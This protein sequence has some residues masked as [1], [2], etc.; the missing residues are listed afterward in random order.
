MFVDICELSFKY[1]NSKSLTINN[2]S[3]SINKGDI[4]AILGE[5]GSGKSTILRLICG[6]ES[7]IRGSIKI[8]NTTI[9][10]DNTFILPEKR[11]IGMVF[12]DYALF[13]HMTT[14]QNI[15]F[16]MKNMDN[17]EK[18][19]RLKQVLDLVSLQQYENRYPYELSGG[20][21]QRVALARALAPEP[22][23][24]LLDEPFSNLDAN[25]RLKIR[26]QLKNII[27]STGTTSIFVT[28]DIEDARN[29]ADKIIVLNEGV[30][31]KSGT[32]ADIFD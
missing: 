28:H 32:P 1:K 29:I 10:D 2:F 20:Q 13:P 27:K 25:L 24:I 30:V 31:V 26:E 11:G 14:A 8:D 5:S 9:V 19:K 6:L 15:R 18:D 12:Q 7:P 23:L 17:S 3:F 4:V 16:G 22:K 21:Q